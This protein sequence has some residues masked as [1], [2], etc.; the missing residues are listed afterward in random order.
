VS[1]DT[2]RETLVI[3]NPAAHNVPSRKRLDQADRWLQ[4]QGW[5][6]EWRETDGPGRAT[7]LAAGAAE[8]GL[9]LVFVCGGD[10]TLNE[11]ANGLA[12]SDTALAVIRAGTVNIWAKEVG[13]PRKPV[14]AVKAAVEGER[15]RIDLGRA[16]EH[17][18]LL[19]AGYGLDGAISRRVHL[20]LK[21]RLGAATYAIAAVRETLRYRSSP[22]TLR[23][24]G[25]EHAAQVLMLVAG[26]TRNYAGLVE[27]TPEAQVDDGLLD[28]CVFQGN[29]KLDIILHVLRT[30]LR[31]HQ[32]SKKVLYRKVRRLELA[33]GEPLPVQLDGDAYELSPTQVE[34]VPDALWVAVPRGVKSPLF[35]Q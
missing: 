26:N 4:A 11:A 8:R 12:G 16:G 27:I 28:V 20:G 33:W 14:A 6:V 5:R 32:Q 19:M 1:T 10:G 7:E 17:Y 31:R 29:A 34:V 18:F 35:R 23:F 13:I 24:D 9:P 21:S 22:V 30:L 2:R 15:R 3:V 25:E